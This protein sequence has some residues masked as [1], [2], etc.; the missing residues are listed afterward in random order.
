MAGGATKRWRVLALMVVLCAVSAVPGR[1]L[2][3]SVSSKRLTLHARNTP[4][5]DILRAFSR[6][7]IAVQADLEFKPPGSASF[8]DADVCRALNTIIHPYRS[9]LIWKSVPGPLGPLPVLAEIRIFEPGGERRLRPLPPCEYPKVVRDPR[10]GMLY[11]ADELLVQVGPGVSPEAFRRLLAEVRGTPWWTPTRPWASTGCGCRP[12]ATSSRWSKPSTGAGPACR[13][14]PTW[15]GRWCRPTALGT[16]RPRPR[17]GPRAGGRARQ[18]TAARRGGG[19]LRAGL[20]GLGGPGGA[21]LR[22]VGPRHPDGLDCSG[23]GARR[24]ALAEDQPRRFRQSLPPPGVASF[25]VGYKGG[26]GGYAGTSISTAWVVRRV[27]DYL[28][29]HPE[30]TRKEICRHLGIRPPK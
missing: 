13:P 1:C 20:T 22:P 18:R 4:L 24:Q 16:T 17:R 25:S 2:D 7:G 23:A 15:L 8:E 30:A 10:S 6:L 3:L 11:V 29:A 5:Q 9:V 27:S 14:R 21:H 26:P 19:P 12:A 28:A